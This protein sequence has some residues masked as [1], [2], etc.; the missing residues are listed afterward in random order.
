MPMPVVNLSK[1][2]TYPTVRAAAESIGISPSSLCTRLRR[3]DIFFG[4]DIYVYKHILDYVPIE[5]WE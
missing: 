5:D 3:G 4:D 2:I 1:N